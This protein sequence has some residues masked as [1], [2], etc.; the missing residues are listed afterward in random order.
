VRAIEAGPR[1]GEPIVLVHGLAIHAYLWRRTFPA[2]IRAG[3]RAFALDLPGHGLS[4][5]PRERGSYTLARMTDH[6]EAFLD[7]FDLPRVVLI[8]QSMGGR[9]SIELAR[10]RPE[11]VRALVLIA[12]VGLGEVSALSH[13][14]ARIP[15]PRGRWS[16][17][18]TR[19]WMLA[20]GKAF[21]YG[22]RATPD[23]SDVDQYWAAARLDGFLPAMRQA[24]LEFDWKQLAPEVLSRLAIPTLVVFGTR[25]RTLRPSG[26]DALVSAMPNGELVW[27][28]DAGHVPNEEASEEVNPIL[29]RFLERV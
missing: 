15:V 17:L 27:V 8:A 5:R 2:L 26:T 13:L 18:L 22:K 29:L 9:I 11:R 28:R 3:Y 4:D 1:D 25:D 20:L 16:S 14:A 12:G 19:R 24:I 7:A 23:P 10:R 6:L 21:A